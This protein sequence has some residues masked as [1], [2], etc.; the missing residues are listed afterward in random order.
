MIKI[1]CAPNAFKGSLRAPAVAR[2]MAKGVR[3]CLPTA[4]VEKIPLADG[5]DGLLDVLL[6]QEGG[7]L[8]DLEITGP[9]GTKI[10][11]FWGLLAD[12]QTAIIETALAAGLAL[13]GDADLNPML[14][15]TYGVG[16]LIGA[17]L[18]CGCRKF[19]VGLGG[20][21]TND[22]GMGMAQALGVKFYDV[23]DKELG[24]GGG[25]LTKIRRI[26]TASL[27]RR[28][29]R[30]EFLIAC[31][32][33]N[34]LTGPRGASM[35]YGPQKGA[36]VA[37]VKELD[38]GMHNFAHV[39]KKELGIDLGKVPGSGAAGGLGAGFLSF[40][41][42]KLVSGIEL[43][44]NRLRFDERIAGA[45][46]ILTGEGSLDGQT[47]FGKVPYGVGKKALA[48]GIPAV[49]IAGSLRADAKDL[50]NHG[51]TALFAITDGP[52]DID[53]AMGGAEDLI[54]G[55]TEEILRLFF[56]CQTTLCKGVDKDEKGT[57]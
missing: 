38:K 15:T 21:A 23:D 43:V 20:S 36:D 22:G 2:A 47:A 3:G 41:Q 55:V 17:A 44:M 4:L 39:I 37:M 33:D 18:D 56:S 13:V 25:E 49:A 35:V 29:A 9:Y 51:L 52:M 14:A 48:Y 50:H 54:A 12:G 1:V 8:R 26:D 24:H 46:L 27:D 45:S 31:D 40:L 34:P 10:N 6:D 42:G 30:A 28:L 11:S 5:G 7:R 57:Y 16:E 19:I 53:A 32:V